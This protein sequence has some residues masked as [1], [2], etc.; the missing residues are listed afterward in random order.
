M[1]T[2]S[3]QIEKKKS[4]RGGPRPGSGRPALGKKSYLL[5]L[6]KANVEAAKRTEKNFSDL[7][8]RLISGWISG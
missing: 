1:Q 6:T 3:P 4:G 7:V 8:D 5:S 2:K